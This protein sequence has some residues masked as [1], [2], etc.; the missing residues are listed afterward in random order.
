MRLGQSL[1]KINKNTNSVI[2]FDKEIQN[3]LLVQELYKT[4]KKKI[5]TVVIIN[6][7]KLLN[8]KIPITTSTK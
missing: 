6:S 2:F 8:A 1:H 4:R 7:D 5:K 3:L